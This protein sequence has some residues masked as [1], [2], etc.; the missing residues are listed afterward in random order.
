MKLYSWNV[1]GIRAVLKKGLFQSFLR[2]H[3]PDVL[4][5]QE[6]KAERG[7][8]EIDVPEYRE[9]WNSAVKK[10]YSGTAIFSR[11]EPLRVV[12]GFP[13]EFAE[14]YSFADELERDSAEEGRVITAEFEKYHLVTVYTPNAKDDLSRLSLRYKHW[15]PAFLAY[16]RQLE[17][18]KPVVL[19]GDLNVAHTELDLANPKPNR[20]KKGFTDEERK[21]FQN[22]LDA[23]FVD[24][25]RL[26]TQGNGHYSWWS[27]FA[28][29]RARNVG[30]R[31][32]YFL[33]SAAL[34]GRV[35]AADIH[36]DVM[37]SD[38]CPVS[39]TLT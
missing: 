12:N 21:G 25:F 17:K 35:V 3:K 10:G 30:W 9:F 23:G 11:E 36:A 31:I 26:F 14:R 33:V 6:T 15:D 1:N 37:G 32:D 22:F 19:C 24:T 7:Q 20:G 2:A 4:C 38:H 18:A 39:V 16:C 28:N 13:H 34:R 27:H 8:I 5:L 29:S